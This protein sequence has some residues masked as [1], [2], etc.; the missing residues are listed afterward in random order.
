MEQATKYG[1]FFIKDILSV[2]GF[3]FF[4]SPK[5]PPRAGPAILLI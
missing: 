2:I 5:K 1:N 3:I 4:L